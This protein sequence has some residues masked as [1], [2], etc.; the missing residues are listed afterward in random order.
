Q[1][2]RAVCVR[3]A[4]DLVVDQSRGEPGFDYVRVLDRGASALWAH[5][6]DCTVRLDPFLDVPQPSQVRDVTRT[7][8]YEIARFARTALADVGGPLAQQRKETGVVEVD[9]RHP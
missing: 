9:D 3:E 1:A 8:E 6:P 7:H 5:D 2:H 4:R